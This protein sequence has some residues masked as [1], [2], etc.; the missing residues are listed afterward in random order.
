MKQIFNFDLNITLADG[1]ASAGDVI[2]L[3]KG[4]VIDDIDQIAWNLCD[5]D[6][7]IQS[8]KFTDLVLDK[9]SIDHKVG[10]NFHVKADFTVN[11]LNEEFITQVIDEYMDSFSD[12]ITVT[13][14]GY[15]S[16]TG[17]RVAFNSSPLD[18]EVE[19][20]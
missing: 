6:E 17:E 5:C 18:W 15:Y 8:E 12:C 1:G 3:Y 16:R 2:A 9:W 19:I 11:A 20:N 13:L 14:N 7:K 10:N 4:R